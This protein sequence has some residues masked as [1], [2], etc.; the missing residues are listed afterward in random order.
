[1]TIWTTESAAL[2]AA[3]I[4]QAAAQAEQAEQAIWGQMELPGWTWSFRKAWKSGRWWLAGFLG[5]FWTLFLLLEVRFRLLPTIPLVAVAAVLWSQ[6]YSGRNAPGREHARLLALETLDAFRAQ[7][8]RARRLLG[9]GA[10]DHS[11]ARRE[12][13]WLEVLENK[14]PAQAQNAAF[15]VRR[16]VLLFTQV[17]D[18]IAAAQQTQAGSE[19]QA[20]SHG[21]G[22]QRR[23]DQ[24][25]PGADGQIDPVTAARAGR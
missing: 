25:R 24:R 15:R 5:A 18:T 4:E 19:H 1:M 3:E 14:N 20:A 12:D 21:A 23:E 16:E 17:L 7:R 9:N 8:Q 2:P 10:A 6:R 13:R 22:R 11:G